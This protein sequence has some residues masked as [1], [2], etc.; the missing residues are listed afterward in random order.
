MIKN[1]IKSLIHIGVVLIT[2]WVYGNIPI[3]GDNLS[4]VDPSTRYMFG[5]P[6]PY[7]FGT[8]G[9]VPIGMFTGTPNL[10][11]PLYTM[12]TDA[13]SIPLTLSYS[14][15]GVRVDE[16]STWTG[17]SWVLQ[18][19]GVINR[20][21]RDLPDDFSGET[22]YPD[23]DIENYSWYDKTKHFNKAADPTVDSEPDLYSYNF[24]G[25]SGK[26][27]FKGETN[28]AMTIP[29]APIAIKRIKDPSSLERKW[30]FEI[31][32]P[33]GYTYYFGGGASSGQLVTQSRSN[34]G[35]QHC[36]ST[37]KSFLMNGKMETSWYLTRIKTPRKQ[38]V[39]FE[40]VSGV[41]DYTQSVSQTLTQPFPGNASTQCTGG[42][43]PPTIPSN[44][45]C[46]LMKTVKEPTLRRIFS[47][48]DSWE[49]VFS[50]TRL[51]W[52]DFG[53]KLLNLI[54]IKYNNEIREV[55]NFEYNLESNKR[56]FLKQIQLSNPKKKY[57]FSY[58][59]PGGLPERLSP[60]QDHWGYFN[61]KNLTSS[62]RVPKLSNH[63]IWENHGIDRS[64]N[65]Q[66]SIKGMLSEVYY[67]TGGFDQLEY[68]GNDEF[69]PSLGINEGVGGVRV[70]RNRT[71]DGV[72]KKLE[73]V[74]YYAKHDNLN[75]SSGDAG[76]APYYVSESQIQ[77][78][79]DLGGFAD[80]Y[81]YHLNSNSLIPLVNT[82]ASCTYYSYV[83]VSHGG[84]NFENGGEEYNYR[85]NRDIP[86]SPLL[87]A[88]ILG[89]TWTNTG[90]N[91]GDLL[92]VS[93]FKR[94]NNNALVLIYKEE[95]EYAAFQESDKVTALVVSKEYQPAI[96]QNGG[97]I[98]CDKPNSEYEVRKLVCSGNH[99][100]Q[101]S[102]AWH[103]QYP[104]HPWCVVG[105]K[106]GLA[107]G[108]NYLHFEQVVTSP[109]WNNQGETI[110]IPAGVDH[111]KV[112]KY[113]IYSFLNYLKKKTITKFDD[114]GNLVVSYVTNYYH[115]NDLHNQ[116]SKV[117]MSDSKGDLLK[118]EFVY[119]LDFYDKITLR[120]SD[121][122]DEQT[123]MIYRMMLEDNVVQKP[124]ET[125]HYFNGDII[126]AEL[127]LYKEVNGIICLDKKLKLF[128]TSPIPANDF[129]KCDVAK[130][131]AG[132]IDNYMF[133]YD[134]R[135][136]VDSEYPKY[137]TG[138]R[139]LEFFSRDLVSQS[140]IWGYNDVLPVSR[141]TNAK[142]SDIAY[143]S[144][145]N[146][147][148]ENSAYTGETSIKVLPASGSTPNWGH[149][150]VII[151][152]NQSKSYLF[153]A[154]VKTEVGFANGGI[155]VDIIRDYG[156]VNESVHGVT[157]VET[158]ISNTNGE[159]SYFQCE[160]NLPQAKSS[161]SIPAN[162]EVSLKAY[163]VNRNTALSFWIDECRIH[164]KEASMVT[165]THKPLVGITSITDER[166]ETQLFEY[167][168]YNRLKE[169][170]DREG[171]ILKSYE[172]NYAGDDIIGSIPN[173]EV[174]HLNGT[175]AEA[176]V[177][178]DLFNNTTDQTIQNSLTF[179][180][181]AS[182]QSQN[183]TI[184]ARSSKTYSKTFTIPRTWTG[185]KLALI[186]G[187][188]E[189]VTANVPIPIDVKVYLHPDGTGLP[190]TAEPE[191][192]FNVKCEV[193]QQ[194]VLETNTCITFSLVGVSQ[195][196]MSVLT[197][198]Q[199][200]LILTPDELTQVTSTILIPEDNPTGYVVFDYYELII[201]SE[202]GDQVVSESR[203][204]IPSTPPH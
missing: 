6:T 99:Q 180:I 200:C 127:N 168:G 87:G 102:M 55:F 198:T 159:W 121:T 45:T 80:Y 1:L 163:S 183:Q 103:P 196:N 88:D 86:G 155:S 172:Y 49:M 68:E 115:D 41:Y 116:V 126:G 107:T 189:P 42:H 77:Q 193:L 161:L 101:W 39:Y 63:S 85:V 38:N 35:L 190:A 130:V 19:G 96:I 7:A 66:Y 112:V 124:I 30:Q 26:F 76:F 188:S 52:S 152:P 23:G 27:I 191:G 61:G 143:T 5:A 145:E 53:G 140:L 195:G 182:T 24:M 129:E 15:S 22:L 91:N 165:Y 113:D 73:K 153:S 154:W 106:L 100:H 204:K 56:V 167:D 141:V 43:L 57:H 62:T 12:E 59:D 194:G 186:T 93:K 4:N 131:S 82:G 78:G 14:S 67:P 134:S 36:G 33:N 2:T 16:M 173:V 58:Y 48:S 75:Q 70:K 111:L 97:T 179:E 150:Q 46:A 118:E 123:G 69:N 148:T 71:Y 92:M 8:Y 169:V 31:T 11:I 149:E 90:Y 44:S 20:T 110:Q 156:G 166:S 108:T 125:V 164:P 147:S 105:Y 13:L 64:P 176:T 192:S 177:S 151:S 18:V 84:D 72:E 139:L 40:Y 65:P 160:I 199:E 181:D 175:N 104:D 89:A 9:Q 37:G 21:I 47:D 17:L 81:Y 146:V 185:Q 114:N 34:Y 136:V 109:C 74:Y 29:Y 25:Y 170:K 32:A 135:Y 83:T 120:S 60:S 171:N 79:C 187:L 94:A 202:S 144:F 132:G 10:Q 51:N 184:Q 142:Q 128:T 203:V 54:E 157:G 201:S 162:E 178:I 158:T 28:V 117:E 122:Y 174:T 138:G 137:S 133:E 119:P 3:E 197:G 50:S 95:S 98:Y